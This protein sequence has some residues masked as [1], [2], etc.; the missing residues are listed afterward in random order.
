MS[1]F[2]DFMYVYKIAGTFYLNVK[3]LFNFYF[4][5]FTTVCH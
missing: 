3:L 4:N 2:L 5:N 1:F